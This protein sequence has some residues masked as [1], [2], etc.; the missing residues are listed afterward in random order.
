[1]SLS[2]AQVEKGRLAA[3]QRVCRDLAAYYAALLAQA[4]GRCVRAALVE[5]SKSEPSYFTGKRIDSVIETS[6]RYELIDGV[7]FRRV[8]DVVEGEVQLR[9]AV[10]RVHWGQYE[11]PGQG[12]KPLGYRE[13]I[14]LE[15]HNGALGGHQGRE[16]TM[17]SLER[18]FWWSGMYSDVRS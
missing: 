4:Q 7:L 1:V 11:M 13:R 17:D 10:P 5:L 9:C 14:P 3:A 2:V 18:D 6:Q 8:Y 12:L 15:Y 16:R